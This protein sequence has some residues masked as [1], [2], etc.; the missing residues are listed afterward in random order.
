MSYVLTCCSTSDLSKEQY[1]QRDLHVIYFHFMLD[2]KEYL[3]DCGETVSPEELFR[4]M[5]AGAE[6]STSQ[7]STSE[8]VEFWEPFLKD[9]KDILHITLSS[10]ISGTYNSAVLACEWLREKYPERKLYVTDSYAAS[11][12][13]GLLMETLADRRTNLLY[14]FS[15]ILS[16]SSNFSFLK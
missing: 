6:T 4:R 8:Y 13:Y 11:S 1:L 10:G 7:I 12:G 5:D 2:G 14:N 16:I 9:G 3:D 15:P